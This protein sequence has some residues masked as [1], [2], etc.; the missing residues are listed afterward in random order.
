MPNELTQAAQAAAMGVSGSLVHRW[1]KA[2]MPKSLEA[3]EEWRKRNVASRKK[4]KT[5]ANAPQRP[6]DT[7]SSQTNT[8]TADDPADAEVIALADQPVEILTGR[9]QCEEA[10]H[11]ARRARLHCER[12]YKET[13]E[14]GE[15][16]RSADWIGKLNTLLARQAVIERAFRDILEQ[17]GLTMSFGAAERTYRQVLSDIRQK[18]L[19]APSALAA[20]LNPQDP[21]HALQTLEDY[22]QKTIFRD[23][24]EDKQ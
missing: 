9:A 23:L 14:A 4:R 19:A 1:R 15:D 3:G 11:A 24:F 18:L 16:A 22:L 8:S 17:D 10:L 21:A 7:L 6:Q 2:G 5:P 13:D 12:R 20:R